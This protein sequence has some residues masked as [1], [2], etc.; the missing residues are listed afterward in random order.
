[1]G[2]FSEGMFSDETTRARLSRRAAL[3]LLTRG[4]AAAGG[5]ALAG[6]GPYGT[7]V[8]P[9]AASATAPALTDAGA[10]AGATL[11]TGRTRVALI[12]PLTQADGPSLVGQSLR[13]AAELALSEALESAAT[14][15]ALDD[16]SSPEGARAAAQQALAQGAQI[17]LGPLYAN[18]VREA[19]RLARAA[20]VPVIA[21]STDATTASPGVYLLSFLAESYVD[22]IVDFATARGKKSFAALVPESDYGNIT[23]AQLQQRA[24]AKGARVIAIERYRPGGAL[25]GAQRIAGLGAQVDALFIPEQADQMQAVAQA[26]ASSGIDGKRV[27][28]LGTGLWNDARVLRLPQLQGAWFAAPENA[29]FNVFAGKY[30]AKFGADPTRIATLA[31]DAMSLAS[32]LGAQNLGFAESTLAS[33][34]GFNGAD[35]LFRFRSDGLNERGLSV[36]QVRDGATTVV[37]PAPRSFSGA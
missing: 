9:D 14:L 16:Q 25:A 13:N 15:I 27:Q 8:K 26:L 10:S 18:N 7:F 33:P 32:A 29:G 34:S 24:A 37:S 1:M 35:G 23:E 6:C 22:R 5:L 30:R 3:R 21:F 12:A 28:I 17:I 36:L 20:N 31:Y 19:G 2:S 4:G 11:G